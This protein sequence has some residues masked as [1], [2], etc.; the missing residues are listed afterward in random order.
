MISYKDFEIRE[1][2]YNQ[3]KS[4]GYS[5]LPMIIPYLYLQ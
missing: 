2:Y 4:V 1:P 3:L 5:R